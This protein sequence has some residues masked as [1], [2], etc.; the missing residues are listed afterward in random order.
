MPVEASSSVVVGPRLR[1][2]VHMN[3]LSSAGAL[4]CARIVERCFVV[5][6]STSCLRVGLQLYRNFCRLFLN[7]VRSCV[8]R[9]NRG[10]DVQRTR[11]PGQFDLVQILIP[12]IKSENPLQ[13][14]LMFEPTPRGTH[15]AQLACSVRLQQHVACLRREVGAHDFLRARLRKV[16][17]GAGMHVRTATR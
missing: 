6:F 3:D 5:A 10:T 14:S 1:L 16:V 12:L 8:K 13:A 9:V 2:G 17:C 11:F 7:A 4:V 15:G